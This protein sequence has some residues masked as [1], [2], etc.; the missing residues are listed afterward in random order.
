MSQLRWTEGQ[1]AEY[2][3]KQK[4][5]SGP[6]LQ[7]SPATLVKPQKYRAQP[8]VIDGIRFDSKAEGKYYEELKLRAASATDPLLFFLRQVPF[9]LPGG[10]KYRADFL[11]VYPDQI[12][13]IDVKGME[14]AQFRDKKKMVEAL[15]P[16]EIELVKR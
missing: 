9:D 5:P 13:V 7:S 8:V 10:V 11:E 12:R 15:Y 4:A 6:D 1:L 2:R 14:T 16:V 3:R